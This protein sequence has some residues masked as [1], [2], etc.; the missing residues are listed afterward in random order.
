MKVK[1]V[2][3]IIFL[4]AL[5]S[6]TTIFFV[7]VDKQQKNKNSDKIQVVVSNFASYDFVRAIIGETDNIELT[8]LVGAGKNTHSYDPTAQDLV[9]I[10]EADLFV[11]VGGEVES[12]A[13]R[14]IG[15]L[16]TS[17]VKILC[18]A[19][20]VD[21]IQ[22]QEID[23]AEHE[24]NE[25]EH[26]EEHEE[27]QH[28]EGAFDEHIWTSPENAIKMINTL[29]KEIELLDI[30]NAET[31]KKNAE[32]YIS[33]IQN[34]DKQIQEIVDNK[35][36]DRLVFGDKMPMQYFIS[37]YGLNVSAAFTGCSTETEPSANTIAY[38]VNVVKK[39]GIPVVLYIEMGNETVAKTIVEEVGGDCKVMQIQTLHNVSK[40]DFD[41][42]ETW[43]SLMERN[44]DVLKDAL[45]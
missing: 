28:D 6:A 20:N 9:T 30:E 1:K 36:R 32:E 38:L 35:V 8:F 37:Y 18:I 3:L 43:V 4:I 23:G 44:I 13:T 45:Q 41:N 40:T 15:T 27:E 33:K 39:E 7:C 29:E 12:W 26:H 5:I 31:Y 24:H 17:D 25:E 42:G 19:D 2:V 22:E 34:V 16:D 21:K 11:Y 14:V 10:Q